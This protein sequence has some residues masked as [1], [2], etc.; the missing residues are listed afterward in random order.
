MIFSWQIATSFNYFNFS[1]LYK[2]QLSQA[3]NDCKL[4]FDELY[5]INESRANDVYFVSEI[6]LG[7]E[8]ALWAN[9]C[10]ISHAS[11]SLTKERQMLLLS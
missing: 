9:K 3:S 11:Q 2:T 5:Y 6:V 4:Q 1:T 8:E 7:Y 10:E